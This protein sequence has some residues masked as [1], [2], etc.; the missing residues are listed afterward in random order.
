[1]GRPHDRTAALSAP[2]KAQMA[3][4]GLV[5]KRRKLADPAKEQ[6]F[7]EESA[8]KYE[9][10][11]RAAQGKAGEKRKLK[12]GG[13]GRPPPRRRLNLVRR[14]PPRK[15]RRGPQPRNFEKSGH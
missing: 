2:T 14:S 9:A 11:W 5:P 13:G 6:A 3:E 12:L 1:M 10:E 4:Y 7:Q 15:R 8:K